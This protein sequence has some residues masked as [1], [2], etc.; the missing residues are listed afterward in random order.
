MVGKDK[1]TRL[2]E[3]QTLEQLLLELQ[4]SQWDYLFIGDGSGNVW[5]FPV[6]FACVV[7]E[8]GTDWRDVFWGGFNCGT[9]NYAEMNAYLNPLDYLIECDSMVRSPDKACRVHICTDSEWLR[10]AGMGVWSRDKHRPTWAKYD[11]YRKYGII[12]M[13]HWIPGHEGILANELCDRVANRLA[14]GA[15]VG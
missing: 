9:N 2:I 11:A 4:I 12:L 5:Q 14:E 3:A 15:I 13:W 10:N 6:G 8:R 7:I 1:K